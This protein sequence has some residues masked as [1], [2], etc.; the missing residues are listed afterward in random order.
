MTCADAERRLAVYGTL[1]PG[2]ENEGMLAPLGGTWSHGTIRGHRL[3]AGWGSTYGYPGVRLAPDGEEI[4]VQVFESA[5]LPAHWDRLDAFEGA[6]YERV[7]VDV[8]AGERI[9]PANV[10]V[11]RTERA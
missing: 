4:A 5:E 2:R 9:V 10:Y 1:A 8:Q 3:E 7:L 6:E 11:I